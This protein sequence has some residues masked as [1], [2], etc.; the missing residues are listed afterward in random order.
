MPF[1]DFFTF[2]GGENSVF[3]PLDPLLLQ[4]PIS[5]RVSKF[6]S[7]N[8]CGWSWN[9]QYTL[10]C[11]S[12]W[13]SPNMWYPA[14][15]YILVF[16]KNK[17]KNSV[18]IACDSNGSKLVPCVVDIL[19]FF[20]GIEGSLQKCPGAQREI[21][22]SSRMGGCG[23]RRHRIIWKL[24]ILLLTKNFLSQVLRRRFP[25]RAR[26]FT[27]T[28]ASTFRTLAPSTTSPPFLRSH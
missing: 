7:Q 12:R 8:A 13:N 5:A 25:R 14:M 6:Q 11:H 24:S 22:A 20:R 16:Y 19:I 4:R 10:F 3:P 15:C 27:F 18:T 9:D 21:V 26:S 1:R 17:N 23:K 2:L 28:F